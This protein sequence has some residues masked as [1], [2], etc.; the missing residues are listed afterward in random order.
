MAS[1]PPAQR[2]ITEEDFNF[3]PVDGAG[4]KHYKAVKEELVGTPVP[5]APMRDAVF[6]AAGYAGPDPWVRCL[7]ETHLKW[8][9]LD[10]SEP[11]PA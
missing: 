11:A 10:E 4:S 7:I 8:A 5:S 6:S 3:L 1:R 2:I 9:A